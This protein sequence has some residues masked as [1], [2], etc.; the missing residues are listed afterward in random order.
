MSHNRWYILTQPFVEL[1]EHLYEHEKPYLVL[2]VHISFSLPSRALHTGTND[3]FQPHQFLCP[4]IKSINKST[5]GI[6]ASSLDT[7][8]GIQF[9]LQYLERI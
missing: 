8:V 5:T 4:G 1:V 6:G 3:S 2:M 7:L 9:C